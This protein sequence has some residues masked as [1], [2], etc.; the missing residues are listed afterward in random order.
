MFDG[1]VKSRLFNFIAFQVGWL[2]CVLGAA[3]AHPTAGPVLAAILLT[4]QVRSADHPPNLAFWLLTVGLLGAVLDSLLALAGLF[5]FRPGYLPTWLCPPWL[6]F[7]WM[8]F[9]ST[10]PSSLAWLAEH[11]RLAAGLGA[12]GGPLS[13]YAGSE[14]GALQ[15]SEQINLSLLI[16]ACLWA[17]LMPGLFVLMRKLSPPLATAA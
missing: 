5:S 7:V 15:L 4:L 13:Y 12:A 11:P 17:L 9:G 8:T 3:S 1:L 6:F 10:L 2:A 16:L 14:L